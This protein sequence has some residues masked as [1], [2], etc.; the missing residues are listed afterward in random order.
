[1]QYNKLEANI[2]T[3]LCLCTN[4]TGYDCFWWQIQG[5][6]KSNYIISNDTLHV[7]LWYSRKF[8]SHK[9]NP[10]LWSEAVGAVS[11]SV[12]KQ[13]EETEIH[14]LWEMSYM[15]VYNIFSVSSLDADGEWLKGV[16][17]ECHKP[18]SRRWWTLTTNNASM[19]LELEKARVTCV[20]PKSTK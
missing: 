14:G 12:K 5:S 7:N 15:E 16:K 17:R 10:T 1:M 11:Q 19:D 20:K 13:S 4:L 3:E 9:D 6:T 8:M 18:S 2:H